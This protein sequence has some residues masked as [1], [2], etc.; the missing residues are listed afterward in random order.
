VDDSAIKEI[1]SEAVKAATL[2]IKLPEIHQC[3]DLL[4]MA[5]VKQL[6]S[7]PLEAHSKLYE[8][9]RL[10]SC[11]KL[12]AFASFHESNPD[13]L[14]SVGIS[15]EDCLKKIRLLSLA[16]LAV[17]HQELPYSLIAQTLRIEESEVEMWIILA[18]SA[19]LIDAKMD[20]LRSVVVINRCTQRVF[21]NAQ[22]KTLHERLHFW[23]DNVQRLLGS[24]RTATPERI[25]IR[26]S[27]D[28]HYQ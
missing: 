6:Q 17:E 13:Y 11:D 16:T 25:P 14:A 28:R 19:L 27:A 9:L 3:D 12:E 15:H 24:I 8:L 23:R 21:T 20:Q 26:S 5:A 10:F 1:K 22:W 7:D 4:E 18:I 2:A